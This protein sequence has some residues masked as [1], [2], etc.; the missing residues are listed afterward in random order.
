MLLY[1]PEH[2][3]C[4]N[5]DSI[6]LYGF[7]RRLKLHGKVLD[8][9]AGSGI[10]GLLSARDFPNIILEAVEKQNVYA[11]F[12]RRNAQINGISYTLYEGDFLELGNHGSYDWIISNPPFY[13]EGVSRS[14]DPILH[15][16]RYNLH[17]PLEAFAQ[18]LGKLLRSKGEVAICYD[19]LQFSE[20]CCAFG[21]AGLRVTEVQ[22]VHSKLDRSAHLV[23]VHAKK[24]SKSYLNVLPP[25]ITFTPEGEYTAEAKAI[26]TQAKVHSIKCPIT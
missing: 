21:R 3:Y 17:L 10:I 7:I 4:Y 23:M 22:F 5:S 24:G 20:L 15:Q 1:Q 14:D 12:S 9:G 26:Y 13:H 16:A 25:L 18:K 11:E 2:G 6:F 8:V 19:A